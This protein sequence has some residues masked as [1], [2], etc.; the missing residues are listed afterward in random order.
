MVWVLIGIITVLVIFFLVYVFGAL[1][2]TR[3]MMVDK[4][5]H[6][7]EASWIKP[8][9]E[10]H[11]KTIETYNEIFAVYNNKIE[12]LERLFMMLGYEEEFDQICK[13]DSLAEKN[14]KVETPE[15]FREL[16]IVK[17]EKD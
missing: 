3:D 6:E 1:P 12:R 10:N 11:E 13:L 5:L 16:S 8:I 9:V 2:A 14:S 15:K 17:K 4:L 7:I